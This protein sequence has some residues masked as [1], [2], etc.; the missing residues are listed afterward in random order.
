MCLS[1]VE[2]NND[3]DPAETKIVYKALLAE[4]NKT[5][6]THTPISMSELNISDAHEENT[7]IRAYDGQNYLAGFHCYAS[8]EDAK[9]LSHAF[10]D[11]VFKCCLEEITALGQEEY[12]QRC[13][14]IYVG[15]KLRFLEEIK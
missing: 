5:P 13:V 7:I 12:A 15:R 14:L 4:K 10:G 8:L 9:V 6:Y 11:R 1:K 3:F 2:R